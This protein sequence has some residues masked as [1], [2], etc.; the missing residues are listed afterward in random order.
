MSYI[1]LKEHE[2]RRKSRENG[3]RFLGFEPLL[4]PTLID[5]NYVQVGDL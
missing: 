5:V 1:F 2:K 3:E 4:R